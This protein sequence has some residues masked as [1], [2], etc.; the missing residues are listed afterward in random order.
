[1]DVVVHQY[2]CVNGNVMLAAGIA[3][4]PPVV[5]AIGVVD[6]D[7]TAVHAALRHVQRKA[8]QFESGQTWHER[9]WC[10]GVETM[11]LCRRGDCRSIVQW[12][13]GDT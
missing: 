10:G 3:E 13:V 8:W 1:M 7:G 4:E 2:E 11:P 5:V 6:K 12:H 9:Q